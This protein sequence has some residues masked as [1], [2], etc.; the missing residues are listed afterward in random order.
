LTFLHDYAINSS[1]MAHEKYPGFSESEPQEVLVPMGAWAKGQ[2]NIILETDGL[3]TCVGVAIHDARNK[4]GHLMHVSGPHSASFEEVTD[5]LGSV[6]SSTTNVAGLKVWV[7]GAG[8]VSGEFV[9]KEDQVE[10]QRDRAYILSELARI[11]IQEENLDAQWHQ[12]DEIIDVSL[13]C[14]TGEFT[15]RLSYAEPQDGDYSDYD[16]LPPYPYF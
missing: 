1:N 9:D 13:N 4:V 15:G 3:S 16:E 7:R 12:S 11:G 14:Q 10:T 6:T 2:G 5:F 8:R